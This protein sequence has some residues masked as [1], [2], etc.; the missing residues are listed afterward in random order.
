MKFYV[1]QKRTPDFQQYP[2]PN[3]VF[4]RS[5]YAFITLFSPGKQFRY[6]LQLRRVRK[7]KKDFYL[8]QPGPFLLS[9]YSGRICILHLFIS[10]L[11]QIF[12]LALFLQTSPFHFSSWKR[13]PSSCHASLSANCFVWRAPGASLPPLSSPDPSTLKAQGWY[14]L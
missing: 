7:L 6:K 14:T 11:M 12:Y 3:S 13:N 8:S 1:Q 4:G 10:Q 9:Y 2:L 5:L